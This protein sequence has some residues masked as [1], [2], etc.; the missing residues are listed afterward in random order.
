[1]TRETQRVYAAN[2]PF[3]RIYLVPYINSPRAFPFE[4]ISCDLRDGDTP[5]RIG[6]YIERSGIYVPNITF[7]SQVVSR[8]HA[9]IRFK[10]GK[11][12]IKD[13]KSAAG[14]FL[15]HIR[16]SSAYLESGWHLLKDGD[17]VQLGADYNGGTGNIHNCVKI[18]I[19]VEVVERQSWKA[20]PNTF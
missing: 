18:R 12:Y 4:P 8:S 15:N 6:R 11:L 13:T 17:I 7:K 14:T 5:L 16:L 20:A 2:T 1:M 19:E 9:E 10:K 3:H